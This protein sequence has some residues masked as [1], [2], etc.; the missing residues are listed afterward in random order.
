MDD[1]NPHAVELGRLGGKKGGKA[2]AK[3]LSPERRR[4]IANKAALVRWSKDEVFFVAD[5]AIQAYKQELIAWLEEEK[6][7]LCLQSFE[8]V[9]DLTEEIINRV[10]NHLSQ[11]DG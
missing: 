2:R 8:A 7:L 11:E 3:K 6:S 10:I 9:K 4:E 1:K 5:E